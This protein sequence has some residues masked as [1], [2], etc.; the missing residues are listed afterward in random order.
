MTRDFRHALRMVARTPVVSAV[1]IVSLG[2]GIGV[3][4]V[5]FS[6]L[7]AT[8]FNPLPAV[9][10]SGDL[11]SIEIRTETGSYP[12][13]SW[14]E[15]RDLSERLTSFEG[16]IA[17]RMVPF[18]IGE[19]GRVE[20]AYGQL[21]SGN[22]FAALG[23]KPAAGRF[24]RDDEAK[25]P[26]TEP[27]AVLSYTFWQAR[28][29]ADPGTVGRVI[30]L[31]GRELSVIGVAPRRFQGTVLG[32]SFDLWVPATMS[33]LLF[34]GSL[35]LQSRNIRGYSAMGRLREG[36][37]DAVARAELD[38]EMKQLARSFPGSN[39]NVRADALKFWEAPRGPPRLLAAALVVLQGLMLLLLLAVCSN[40]ANLVLARASARQ[41]EMGIRLALGATP[42]GAARLIL[43]ENVVLAVAGAL[44]GFVLAS[45]WTPTLISLPL[46]GLPIR[47]QTEVDQSALLFA[48][49]LGIG[50][51]VLSAAAPAFHLSRLDP[52]AA[53][54]RGLVS[55]GRS[56]LRNTL[57]AIQVGLALMV[58]IVAG[59]FLRS[60]ED[61][62]STE[63]GF[64][65]EG[66]L[67]AAY[68]LTG[69][70]VPGDRTV[71]GR[72]FASRLL[73]ALRS[74]PSIEAAAISSSVPLD[75]HGLPSRS[76]VLEGHERADGNQDEALSNIVTPGYLALMGIPLVAGVDFAALDDPIAP[77]QA[78]VN[79]A[80]VRQ[81]LEGA[82]S[83]A[84]LGRRLQVRGASYLIVGV[85]RNS[86]YD[87]FGEPPTP[88]V[89]YSYRDR[90]S[91]SGEIHVRGRTATETSL[92]PDLRR[93]IR[94]IDTDLPLFN[95][96]TM[97]DHIETNLVF[98]RV[99]ARLFGVLGPLLLILAASG[100]YAVVSYTVS[101]RAREV[102]V[103]MALGATARRVM[104]EL[105]SQNLA[106]AVA[107]ALCGWV[108]TVVVALDV[109]GV[110]RIEVSVFAGV[111]LLLLSI[112]A[113][114]CWIPASRAARVDPMIVLRDE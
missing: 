41:R 31:N 38:G 10:R 61:T 13:M 28:F 94:T 12:G 60:F 75:I 25:R 9:R 62:R 6:W 44:A 106:V 70:P 14:L 104:A 23:L 89:Y 19:P 45:W 108:L 96:R 24:F 17:F 40:T 59:L 54:R 56:G 52:Q 3:N 81:Y 33:P 103:R 74:M 111:P 51:G 22:Y 113:V 64:R 100:I 5:V 102:G 93:A 79:E 55:T 43:A 39:A 34:E 27:V 66:T 53:F 92:V 7:Q 46:S 20:R 65:R 35:D 80:F 37:T 8:I 11:H 68:D 32:L 47:F 99:P 21:V 87:A 84:A 18:Y 82:P 77:A 71:F 90:P 29:G 76:F 101:L 49:L 67:L 83:D 48:M 107:G 69:R 72:V 88:I 95:I 50:C 4:T 57:M 97:V 114:A 2:V 98:R 73:Q 85:A 110:D 16:L 91:G 26:G 63:T 105:V 1:I 36:I 78:I 15:F 112:A 42:W 30:R 109:V 86:L 58:L